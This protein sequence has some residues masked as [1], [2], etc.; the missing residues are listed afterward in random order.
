MSGVSPKENWR[1]HHPPGASAAGVGGVA[2]G[3][4]I[5]VGGVIASGESSTVTSLAVRRGVDLQSAFDRTSLDDSGSSYGDGSSSVYTDEEDSL[6][7]P[8]FLAVTFGCLTQEAA[9]RAQCLALIT[10]PY[11]LLQTLYITVTLL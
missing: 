9:P 3:G 10:N 4:G 5:G 7:Y 11:P 1:G 8:G 2:G 6:P